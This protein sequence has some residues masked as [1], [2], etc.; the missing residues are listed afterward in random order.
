MV[1]TL[2]TMLATIRFKGA[3][4]RFEP[5]IAE[6]QYDQVTAQIGVSFDR[7]RWFATS[8]GEAQ[9]VISK[10]LDV[11]TQSRR[12]GAY[13][14]SVVNL[15]AGWK[16]PYVQTPL[17]CEFSKDFESQANVIRELVTPENMGNLNA[18]NGG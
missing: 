5:L 18:C 7:T 8:L 6:K 13:W 15:C 12:R 4:Y 9:I 14:E 17:F 3:P 10:H 1:I 16:R 2:I 11:P